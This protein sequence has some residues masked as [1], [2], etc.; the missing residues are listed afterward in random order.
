MAQTAKPSI[1]NDEKQSLLAVLQYLKKKN[2]KVSFQEGVT[3]C[4]L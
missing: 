4:F 1:L 2:L 3:N